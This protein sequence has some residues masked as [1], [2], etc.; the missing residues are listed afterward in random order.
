MLGTFRTQRPIRLAPKEIPCAKNTSSKAAHVI[1]SCCM[2]SRTETRPGAFYP[3]R[4]T[5]SVPKSET[6]AVELRCSV[7]GFSAAC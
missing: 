7:R 5:G 6:S 2:R 3:T 4:P 1:G